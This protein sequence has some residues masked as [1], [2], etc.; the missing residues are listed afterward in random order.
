MPDVYSCK[1]LA[2]MWK[3]KSANNAATN[4]FPTF[5]KRL[6]EAM[7]YNPRMLHRLMD[8]LWDEIEDDLESMPESEIEHRER[9][10]TG[11]ADRR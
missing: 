1:D 5:R 4:A 8:I 11:R 3:V 2:N 9:M 7:A 6:K 10:L